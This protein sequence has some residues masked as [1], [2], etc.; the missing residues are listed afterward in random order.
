VNE[1]VLPVSLS[2]KGGEGQEGQEQGCCN[3]PKNG[4]YPAA[5]AGNGG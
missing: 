5:V 2:R 3:N 1:E 4:S